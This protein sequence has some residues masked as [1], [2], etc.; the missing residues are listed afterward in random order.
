MAG[1]AT[2]DGTGENIGFRAG[3][4]GEFCRYEENAVRLAEAVHGIA[5]ARGANSA[6]TSFP[7]EPLRGEECEISCI[8]QNART[9]AFDSAIMSTPMP[10]RNVI[11]NS[12]TTHGCLSQ[13]SKKSRRG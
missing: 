7:N 10:V 3:A 8:K 4:V 5:D 1:V 9:V 13:P 12:N 6:T 2:N 11:T